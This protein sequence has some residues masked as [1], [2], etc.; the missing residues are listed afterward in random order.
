MGQEDEAAARRQAFEGFQVNENL[1][2]QASPQAILMHPMPA[3]Y[4]EEVPSGMLLHPRSAA[5]DQAGNRLYAQ[6]AALRLLVAGE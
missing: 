4:G 6:K 3:H 5:F 1:L 2:A